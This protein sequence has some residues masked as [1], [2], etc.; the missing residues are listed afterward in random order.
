MTK[1]S[2][3][4]LKILA[5]RTAN[6]INDNIR[7]KPLPK[8]VS[9]LIKKSDVINSKIQKLQKENSEI[10][11]EITKL[12]YTKNYVSSKQKYVFTN[13]NDK[14]VSHLTIYEDIVLLNEFNKKDLPEIEKELIAKY[15]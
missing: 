6:V 5:S 12:G 11:D 3:E 15:S 7:N 1:I 9:D 10:L 8:N 13:K 4:A 14:L 2:K